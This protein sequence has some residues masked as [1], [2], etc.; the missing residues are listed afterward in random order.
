MDKDGAVKR[1]GEVMDERMEG[2]VHVNVVTKDELATRPS[3]T[4]SRSRRACGEGE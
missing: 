4:R 3:L 1:D 2:K